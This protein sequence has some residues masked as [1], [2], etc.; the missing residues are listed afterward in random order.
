MVSITLT[1]SSSRR[2]LVSAL[3]RLYTDFN[4]GGFAWDYG[5]GD[6]IECGRHC[7]TRRVNQNASN[8]A[9]WKGWILTRIG[10]LG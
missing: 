3:S 6:A 7:D 9:V 8:Y 5:I 10:C 2:Y 4:L 1:L